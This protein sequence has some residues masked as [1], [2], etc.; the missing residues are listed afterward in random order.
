MYLYYA[1]NAQR[2][3]LNLMPFGCRFHLRSFTIIHAA[4][5]EPDKADNECDGIDFGQGEFK[6]IVSR[7]I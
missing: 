3:L 4:S 7:V 6:R 1:F 5:F 2:S